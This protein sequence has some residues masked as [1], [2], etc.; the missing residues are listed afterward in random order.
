MI[1]SDILSEQ[2]VRVSLAENGQSAIDQARTEFF[3]LILMDMQMPV[4]NGLDATRQI[5]LIAGYEAIPI[6]ALTANV[7]PEHKVQAN[8]AGMND[9]LGKPFNFDD[10]LAKVS[11]WLQA[12]GWPENSIPEIQR[13]PA[14]IA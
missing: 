8:E 1:L 2:Q 11:Y 12:R 7:Q 5:R 4:L 9:F 3:D 14:S 6:I 10:L 13:Q